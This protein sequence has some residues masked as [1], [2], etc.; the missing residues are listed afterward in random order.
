MTKKSPWVPYSDSYSYKVHDKNATGLHKREYDS[1]GYSVPFTDIAPSS[2][3]IS[4]SND[5]RR[6]V[7]NSGSIGAVR[8]AGFLMMGIAETR[9]CE[10]TNEP[11]P[12]S[13]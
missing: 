2:P 13:I 12:R 8:Y 11:T 9:P 5:W 10:N 6:A 3:R 7:D 1:L 4:S